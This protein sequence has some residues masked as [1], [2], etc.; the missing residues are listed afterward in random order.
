MSKT[1]IKCALFNST[2]LTM[3][4][5]ETTIGASSTIIQVLG[6]LSVICIGSTALEFYDALKEQKA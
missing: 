5:V 6:T 3:F 4:L 2:L 1:L